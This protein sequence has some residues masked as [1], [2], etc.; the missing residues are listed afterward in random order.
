MMMMREGGTNT[1]PANTLTGR[2][3][4]RVCAFILCTDEATYFTNGWGGISLIFIKLLTMRVKHVV[5]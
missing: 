4:R 3:L 1:F 2:G 5:Q